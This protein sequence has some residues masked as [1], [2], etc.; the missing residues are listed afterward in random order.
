MICEPIQLPGG[1]TGLACS[2]SK[3]RPKCCKCGQPSSRL[4]DFVTVPG[5]HHVRDQT[6]DKPLCLACAIKGAN[7]EDYCPDHKLPAGAQ[8]KMEGL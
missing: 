7:G 5:E 3:R 2:R 4:C 1:V 6:C 8:L